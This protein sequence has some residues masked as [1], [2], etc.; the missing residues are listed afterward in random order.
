[1]WISTSRGKLPL[2]EVREEKTTSRW[3]VSK[4]IDAQLFG[5]WEVEVLARS[6]HDTRTNA[7]SDTRRILVRCYDYHQ[8]SM[9]DIL[10]MSWKWRQNDSKVTIDGINKSFEEA[11]TTCCLFD[12]FW[13]GTGTHC[14]H[15]FVLGTQVT[16]PLL[17]LFQYKC[18][19]HTF[20]YTLKNLHNSYFLWYFTVE[21]MQNWM[22]L[23]DLL[24]IFVMMT[25]I[26]W[27][28]WTNNYI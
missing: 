16:K 23:H 14:H 20:E 28:W 4:C 21:Y 6:N 24:I 17:I 26:Q 12:C 10:K 13:H 7:S 8:S 18:T 5:T 3:L 11:I 25:T 27:R 19:L 2:E 9:H 1:M 15:Q 22:R